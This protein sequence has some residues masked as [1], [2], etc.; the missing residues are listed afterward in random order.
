MM[1]AQ[2]NAYLS[3]CAIGTYLDDLMH[4]AQYDNVSI[5][6]IQQYVHEAYHGIQHYMSHAEHQ[7]LT[8][9]SMPSTPVDIASGIRQRHLNM[10]HT[11]M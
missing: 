7:L 3:V 2:L 4:K 11:S 9:L 8:G 1:T 6:E 10:Y 5:G